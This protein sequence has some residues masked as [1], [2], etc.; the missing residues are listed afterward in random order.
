MILTIEVEV[1][2]KMCKL[3]NKSHFHVVEEA[4]NYGF[5]KLAECCAE[6]LVCEQAKAKD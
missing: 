4:L 2:D 6:N 1:S 3:L 5:K